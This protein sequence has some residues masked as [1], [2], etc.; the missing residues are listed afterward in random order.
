MAISQWSC[1]PLQRPK[2]ISLRSDLSLVCFAKVFQTK[3]KFDQDVERVDAT[4]LS[5]ALSDSKPNQSVRFDL[6]LA[7]FCEIPLHI[8]CG[9]WTDP[10]K[11]SASEIPTQ[12]WKKT[13]ILYL[14]LYTLAPVISNAIELGLAFK[15]V[16]WLTDPGVLNNEIVSCRQITLKKP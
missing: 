2:F 9:E 6:F 10:H 12:K 7:N 15:E 8:C 3:L 5:R 11:N 16:L 4:N 1:W 13:Q 14:Y